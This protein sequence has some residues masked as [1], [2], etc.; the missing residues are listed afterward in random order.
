MRWLQRRWEWQDLEKSEGQRDKTQ[1]GL[2]SR[3]CFLFDVLPHWA[4]SW[5]IYGLKLFNTWSSFSELRLFFSNPV[6]RAPLSHVLGVSLQQHTWVKWSAG[7]QAVLKLDSDP[8]IRISC[9]GV[10]I[11]LQ[12]A[13]WTLALPLRILGY[14]SRLFQKAPITTHTPSFSP[15]VSQCAVWFM[16]I[17]PDCVEQAE[18][19]RKVSPLFAGGV[20]QATAAGCFLSSAPYPA[21]PPAPLSVHTYSTRPLSP[22]SL[23][24]SPH[25][26]L[27]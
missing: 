8:F 18:H 17:D 10:R 23:L 26:C 2:E 7:H 19:S 12:N 27:L 11:R 16:A 21:F 4:V 6:L 1:T 9:V 22:S 14:E 5:C 15:N 20:N 24:P 13:S 25:L 3:D